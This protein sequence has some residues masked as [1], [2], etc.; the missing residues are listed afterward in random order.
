[1]WCKGLPK[2]VVYFQFCFLCSGLLV[3]VEQAGLGIELSVGG[4]LE[5]CCL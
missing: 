2:G 3:A 5:G 4:M 1:M